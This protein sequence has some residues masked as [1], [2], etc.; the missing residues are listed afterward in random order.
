MRVM[1]HF[2]GIEI[3]CGAGSSRDG[4]QHCKQ[5]HA[6]GKHGG[7]CARPTS[8]RGFANKRAEHRDFQEPSVHYDLHLYR[9]F[10][11]VEE[12]PYAE[13]DTPEDCPP[14]LNEDIRNCHHE[15]SGC[16]QVGAETGE[17][18][19]ECGDDENH[20]DRGDDE[21]HYDDRDGVEKC[22][23]DLAF[24][25]EDL[26]LVSCKAVE[27]AVQDTG[28]FAGAYQVAEQRVEVQRV[29]AE[30]DIQAVARFDLVLDVHGEFA[31]R[32]IRMAL[33]DDIE[34]LKQGHTGFH[35]GRELPS[36]QGNVLVRNPAA[37]AAFLA[38]DL[39]DRDALPAQL[40]YHD[41]FAA[42]THIAFDQLSALVL[43]FPEKGIFLDLVSCCCRCGS[44][45]VTSS[46]HCLAR[47][48]A[49][50]SA[51]ARI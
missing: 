21:G 12:E 39:Q 32:R 6:R 46:R 48:V 1:T 8:N 10:P 2:V 33:A 7:K 41:I 49:T 42:G 18:I 4:L 25:R 5:R 9:T 36:E 31:D 14:P 51:T 16:G 27:Q 50:G 30:R 35:H 34:G 23:L 24:D 15:Q 28:L 17:Q 47:C 11:C 13:P 19:L 22:R 45:S 43:A 3:G 44:H 40:G 37:A 26:F 38:F 29:L 20:D